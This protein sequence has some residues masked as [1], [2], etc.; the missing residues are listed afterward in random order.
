MEAELRNITNNTR[1]GQPQDAHGINQYSNSMDFMDT[2][3]P[4]FKEAVEPLEVDEW[5][6]T[7]E[8][9]FHLLRLTEDLKIEYT[10][11]QL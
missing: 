4:I 3:P 10:T 11:H 9:K 7:M 2:R 1:H 5:T 8:Q 6:N